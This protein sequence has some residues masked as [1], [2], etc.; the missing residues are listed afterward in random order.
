M[1]RRPFGWGIEICSLL[2]E[3]LTYGRLIYVSEIR[4][5]ISCGQE[6]FPEYYISQTV[7]ISLSSVLQ[8]T[9]FGSVWYSFDIHT[10]KPFNPLISLAGRNWLLLCK[11][12]INFC[13]EEDIADAGLLCC[14]SV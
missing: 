5:F 12:Q 14:Y 13:V 8:M 4:C 1:F 6:L 2:L 7:L 3:P 10:H 9:C 11:R